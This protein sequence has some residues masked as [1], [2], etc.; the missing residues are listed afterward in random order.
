MESAGP[1]YDLSAEQW[2]AVRETHRRFCEV[3]D[4]GRPLFAAVNPWQLP[5]VSA[6]D[7]PA[8]E[9]VLAGP[10]ER[11]G[12]M[13]AAIRS[14]VQAAY[15]LARSEHR[16]DSL[17]SLFIP[18]GFY[19]HS[20]RLAEPFGATV[21]VGGHAVAQADPSLGS[22]SEAF[23]LK[24]K[25]RKDCPWLSR[26]LEVLRYFVESTEGRYHVSHMVTT[27]PCDTVNYATGS[28]MLLTG[29]YENPRAVHQL[30]RMA[31]D[32]IIEHILDCRKI[33]GDLL[34]SDHTGLLDGCYCICSEIRSQFSAAH[35]EEFEAPYLK[36][37]GEA[38]GPLHIH[39]SGPVQHSIPATLADPNIKHVRFWLRD[40][41]LRQ[42]VD[43]IGDRISI[44]LFRND[45]MPA[46]S[47]PSAADFYAH[48][49]ENVRPETR[50]V[51]PHYEPD[52]F[53]EAY[54]R[55]DAAGKLPQQVRRFGRFA[56]GRAP[57]DGD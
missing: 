33:A 53:N 52:A 54:D 57:G 20:Q 46:L 36:E 3:K 26:S 30:L 32:V 35:C 16:Y 37:I 5:D 39:V 25:S 49:F 18:R 56:P 27:G 23:H 11:D 28:T 4:L 55:M 42:V 44:N 40:S 24:P 21:L 19:G 47:F 2:Q 8:K 38:V 34:V 6:E 29:F 43:L 13:D 48:V 31:T 17:P 12:E 51:I 45:C 15:L 50:W 10:R 9:I 7:V 1:F 22:L 41:D 14:C